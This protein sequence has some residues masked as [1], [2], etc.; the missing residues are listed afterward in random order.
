MSEARLYHVEQPMRIGFDHPAARRS[1]SDSLVLSLTLDGVTGI[2]ECAPRRYVTGET[3]GSVTEAL[4]RTSLNQVFDLL[5]ATPPDELLDL[6]RATGFDAVFGTDRW[7]SAGGNLVCLLETAVLDLLGHRLSMPASRFLPG[8]PGRPV[9]P[10]S[11][12]LDLSI[13]AEEFVDTRGP[14]HFV[15]VKASGDI[16]RDV[17]TVTVIRQ[18]LGSQVPVMVD[19]NMSWTPE[20]AVPYARRLRACGV[21][22]VEEPLPPRSWDAL[23]DLR[24]R[25]GIRV[26]LDESVCTG[27]DAEAA[28]AAQAC[29]AVNVRVAKNGGLLRSARLI[30]RLRAAGLAFQIGVQVAETGPLINAGRTLAFHNPDALTVEAGQ[31]DRFFAEMI[32]SPRPAVDRTTNTV[33]PHEGPGFGMRLNDTAERWAVRSWTHGD[34]HPTH[35]EETLR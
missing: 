5:R 7:P 19:A 11:Q 4:R 22:Q 8:D 17:R 3:A 23:R 21:D 33:V 14:F 16:E 6:L 18:R 12:V 32:V 9:L 35:L 27:Q 30:D 20:T 15:K 10:V 25:S 2:G 28:I 24:R 34:W 31:S 1:T 13:G 29:D 26:M